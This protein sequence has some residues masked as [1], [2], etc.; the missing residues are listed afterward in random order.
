M[1]RLAATG[2][3]PNK[4]G[5][6]YR[7]VGPYSDHIRKE[8]QTLIDI[9]LKSIPK[10]ELILISGMALGVDMLWAQ[11]AIANGLN[12]VAAIPCLGQTAKWPVESH[13]LYLQLLSS[14]LCKPYYTHRAPYNAWCMQ[15]R[16]EWM[17][18]NCEKL[19]AI[20][21]GSKGDTLNC[22]KYAREKQREILYIDPDYKKITR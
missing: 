8:M 2:H 16:N 12:W 10:D 18:D 22:I 7:L 5:N 15:Y 6:E 3:R 14:P 20:W 19:V 1:I 17:V 21:D 11:I 9:Y 4:L 13:N